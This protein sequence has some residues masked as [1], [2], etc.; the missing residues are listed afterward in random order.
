MPTEDILAGLSAG[1]GEG[2]TV[3]GFAAQFG[4]DAIGRAREK[5]DSKGAD[6]IVLNDVSDTGIGFDSDENAVT[7]VTGEDE[8]EVARAAKSD[9]AD[10]ILDRVLEIRGTDEA[11]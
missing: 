7:L 11:P 4:G 5:L 6:L 3:V 2:Q 1:R 9:I 10:R 8:R